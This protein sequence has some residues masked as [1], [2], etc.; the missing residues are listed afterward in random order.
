LKFS[1]RGPLGDD[2]CGTPS[3]FL[4]TGLTTSRV[5]T[6]AALASRVRPS[7]LPQESHCKILPRSIY[8]RR[9][10]LRPCGWGRKILPEFPRRGRSTRRRVFMEFRGPKAHSNRHRVSATTAETRVSPDFRVGCR[11]VPGGGFSREARSSH[12]RGS[13]RPETSWLAFSGARPCYGPGLS[14]FGYL[15]RRVRRRLAR[16]RFRCS[17]RT[18]RGR[19]SP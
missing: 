1:S 11:S 3:E 9:L 13:E 19:S 15:P 8:D 18:I 10:C 4:R 5:A 12:G 7:P 17:S 6:T 14:W 2:F 16:A